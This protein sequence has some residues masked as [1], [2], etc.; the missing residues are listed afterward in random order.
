[1]VI[2]LTLIL[3]IFFVCLLHLLHIFI[4]LINTFTREANTINPDQ[5][6]PS[7]LWVHTVCNI[8]LKSTSADEKVG[9]NCCGSMVG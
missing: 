5:T 7:L 3:P 4:A 2:T 9:Y 6:A 1:M 8:G